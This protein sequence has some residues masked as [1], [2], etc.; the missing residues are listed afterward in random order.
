M[1]SLTRSE[2]GGRQT[3][4]AEDINSAILFLADINKGTCPSR[5]GES[6][7]LD[8]KIWSPVSL[9]PNNDCAVE[10]QQQ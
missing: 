6:Q 10:A 4:V 7:I 2:I 3:P 8:S 9:G 5:L 1:P